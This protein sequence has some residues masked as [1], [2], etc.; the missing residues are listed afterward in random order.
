MT[1]AEAHR[2][3]RW[4]AEAAVPQPGSPSRLSVVII[5]GQ[6]Q[7][8]RPD[9]RGE[10]WGACRGANEATLVGQEPGKPLRAGE[11]MLLFS[12][13]PADNRCVVLGKQ[14]LAGAWTG[15]WP[16]CMQHH[17]WQQLCDA[18]PGLLK[19]FEVVETFEVSPMACC[20]CTPAHAPTPCHTC[21][22]AYHG[23]HPCP[24]P[25]PCATVHAPLPMAWRPCR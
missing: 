3:Q 20:L 22:A 12:P 4:F 23:M 9:W 5:R 7:G 25:C 6:G 13:D 2:Q 14:S 24:C 1:P 10:C 19:L 21:P 15:G 18:H 11:R 16:R 17:R 8:N